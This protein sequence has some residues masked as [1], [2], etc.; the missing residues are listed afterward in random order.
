MSEYP[1]TATVSGRDTTSWT[2]TVRDTRDGYGIV[3]DRVTGD[4]VPFRF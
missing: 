2:V 3:F 1:G 4:E